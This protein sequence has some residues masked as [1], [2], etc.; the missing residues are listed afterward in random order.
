MVENKIVPDEFYRYEEE[1]RDSIATVDEKGKRI[2]IYPKKPKGK[3]HNARVV[4]T[5]IL[6]TIFFAGPFIKI[7]GQ[8]L[9]MLN[10]FD[11]KFVI[12]G[13]VFWPQDFFLLALTLLTFFVFII[14]FTVVYGRVWCGWACP[15]TLFMEMVFRKIEYWI[16]GDAHAQRRLDKQSWNGEKILKKGGK[17][18]IF[19]V[20][21]VI[22]AHT[23][24]AYLI[25]LKDTLKI[26]HTSPLEHLSGFA[27]LTIFTGIFYGVFALFREQACTAVCPYGRL[28]GVLLGKESIV[29]AYDWLRGEPRGKLKKNT[30]NRTHG[31]CID[32]KLC[33]HVCPTGID[34]R[35]G[36]QLECVNCTACIDACDEVMLKINKPTGLIRFA[37]FN[38]IKEGVQKIITS[39]V[40]AYSFVLIALLGMLSFLVFTRSVIETTV[41]KVPGTLYQRTDD[42]GITNLYNV[43]F[44]N[45][46][47]EDIPLEI[48]IES[49]GNAILKQTGER[50]LIVPPED[51]L[52][53]VC[54]IKIPFASLQTA[55]TKVVL[56]VYRDGKKIE[57]IKTTFI[58]PIP[59]RRDNEEE[60]DDGE[61]D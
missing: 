42:G 49:P 52:K 51:I 15:Q 45:K 20:L 6:L 11:R 37:S 60:D 21:S 18:L 57:N 59:S 41:L 28:Q 1:F 9:L 12:A 30:D 13:Q 29:V 14:L 5:T 48:K 31:D 19:I 39:K 35:N 33:V 44:V 40:I 36:T 32:C 27:G 38:S 34:I 24:M 25:G 26:I 16:E 46:T 7:G 61:H 8:P 55:K 3:Y 17:Q 4:V 54:I 58:G 2:W 10:F 22:I 56:G 23:A 43:E 47:F 50:A 53:T